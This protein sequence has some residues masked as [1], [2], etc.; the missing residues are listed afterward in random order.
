M[1][2]YSV[3]QDELSDWDF[4]EIQAEAYKWIVYEYESGSYDGSGQA[5]AFKEENGLLYV[6]NLGH[7]SCYGPMDSWETDCEVMTVA[8]FLRDK[9][10]IMD[11]DCKDVVKNKVREHVG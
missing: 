4:K 5:V 10:S 1:L 2:I 7:C 9:D 3:G 11:T 8:E 6:K